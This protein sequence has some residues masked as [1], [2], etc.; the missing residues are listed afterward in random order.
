MNSQYKFAIVGCGQIAERHAEQ[1]KRKGQ[2]LAACDIVKEKANA[3]SK[4]FSAKAYYDIE[5][6]LL[7]EKEIDIIS[8]CTPNGLHAIHSIKSLQAGKHVLCEKP[9]AISSEDA[10]LMIE[11]EKRTG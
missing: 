10:K 11:T 9:M 5:E 3:F 6:L 1:I 7:Q 4:K 8:V 2:L